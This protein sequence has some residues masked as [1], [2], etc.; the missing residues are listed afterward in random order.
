MN[1]ILEYKDNN[2]DFIKCAEVKKAEEA[3]SYWMH[4]TDRPADWDFDISGNFSKFDKKDIRDGLAV[5]GTVGGLKAGIKAVR[6]EK[7][8]ISSYF[9]WT[10]QVSDGWKEI[11]GNSYDNCVKKFP[12][13]D[14]NEL[15]KNYKKFIFS[16]NLNEELK[17]SE[18]TTKKIKI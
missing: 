11:P 15:Y 9:V 2:F 12:Q 18:N 6:N 4:L 13:F 14:I 7:N 10:Y 17:I 3:I 8:R 1:K 5:I 16:N